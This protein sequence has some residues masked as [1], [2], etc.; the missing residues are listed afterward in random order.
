[1]KQKNVKNGTIS[2]KQKRSGKIVIDTKNA[3]IVNVEVASINREGGL[4]TSRFNK[5]KSSDS[6]KK[7]AMA[8][9]HRNDQLYRSR[10]GMYRSEA[11]ET[12]D[13]TKKSEKKK[14]FNFFNKKKKGDDK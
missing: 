12:Y 6:I 14:R 13:T 8:N 2:I 3:E 5:E 11:K 10:N 1:M 7:I 4:E 9:D